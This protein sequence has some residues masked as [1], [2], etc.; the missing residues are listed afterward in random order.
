MLLNTLPFPLSKT[1]ALLWA[2]WTKNTRLSLIPDLSKEM[3][4]LFG[5]RKPPVYFRS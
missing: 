4:F 2:G 5:K 1:E 3:W